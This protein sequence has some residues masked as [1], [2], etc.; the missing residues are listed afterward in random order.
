ML[1]FIEH[2]AILHAKFRSQRSAVDAIVRMHCGK[3]QGIP[4]DLDTSLVVGG[5][6][7]IQVI[8]IATRSRRKL[9]NIF[10]H[11]SFIVIKP[12]FTALSCLCNR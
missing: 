3:P 12:V 4:I 7:S 8:G 2:K 11:R 5:C 1:G 10:K 9:W 6:T